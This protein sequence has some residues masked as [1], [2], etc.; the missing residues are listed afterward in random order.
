MDYANHKFQCYTAFKKHL[1]KLQFT[2]VS[3]ILANAYGVGFK[4]KDFLKYTVKITILNFLSNAFYLR[5]LFPWKM[6]KLNWKY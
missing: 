5:H 2:F 6:L 4:K 1:N 3:F